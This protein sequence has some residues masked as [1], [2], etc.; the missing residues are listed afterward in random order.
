MS[1]NDCGL[2]IQF[3]YVHNHGLLWIK[4]LLNL[5][6]NLLM[7]KAT[8]PHI[9]IAP[10]PSK[11]ITARINFFFFSSFFFF[12]FFFFWRVLLEDP[13]LT[14]RSRGGGDKWKTVEL[15]L[16]MVQWRWSSWC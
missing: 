5:P 4:S 6:L 9:Q 10:I 12:F 14:Y 11:Q 13:T 15:A 16:V 1:K 7:Y 3:C 8:K 2:Q